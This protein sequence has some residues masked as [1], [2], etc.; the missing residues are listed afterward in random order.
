VKRIL[1][2]LFI[3]SVLFVFKSTQ[4]NPVSAAT[5]TGTFSNASG[6]ISVNVITF[7]KRANGANACL[8]VSNAIAAFS[9]GTVVCTDN[10]GDNAPYRLDRWWN[11]CGDGAS[12]IPLSGSGGAYTFNTIDVHCTNTNS[13]LTI[14]GTSCAGTTGHVDFRVNTNSDG[15]SPNIKNF[16]VYKS[17]GGNPDS[18]T[19]PLTVA[20][21]A[22]TTTYGADLALGATGNYNIS[23]KSFTNDPEN[24][25]YAVQGTLVCG[26]S[27]NPPANFVA[28]PSCDGSTDNVSFT[29]TGASPGTFNYVVETTTN[30]SDPGPTG[31]W[32]GPQ[33]GPT[34]NTYISSTLLTQAQTYWAHVKATPSPATGS[35]Y[36]SQ[37][38][39]FTVPTCQAGS[40]TPPTF[41]EDQDARTCASTTDTGDLTDDRT[42][43]YQN[44]V[45][46]RAKLTWTRA[47]PTNPLQ[48]QQEILDYGTNGVTYTAV[49]HS[50]FTYNANGVITSGTKRMHIL[51][52]SSALALGTF[53]YWRIRTQMTDGSWVT[54]SVRNFSTPS[55]CFFTPTTSPPT[56]PDTQLSGYI[57][58]SGGLRYVRLQFAVDGS[59]HLSNPNYRFDVYFTS[60]FGQTGLVGTTVDLSLTL[61]TNHNFSGN[62]FQ[63]V[64][65]DG[66]NWSDWDYALSLSQLSTCNA[67]TNAPSNLVATPSCSG[68]TPTVTFSFT[69]N[70]DNENGF[71]LDVTTEPF[72][73]DVASNPSSTWGTVLPGPRFGTGSSVPAVTWSPSSLLTSGNANPQSAGSNLVPVEATTYYWRVKALGN[74]ENS[75]YKYDDGTLASSQYPTGRSFT[76]APCTPSANLSAAIVP[77]SWRNSNG[78]QTQSFGVGE[79]VSVQI[80]VTNEPGPYAVTSPATELYFYFKGNNGVDVVPSCPGTA[81]LFPP[82]VDGAGLAQSYPISQLLVS[83]TRNITVTFNTGPSTGSATAYGYV[84]PSC[85]Y[86]G[87]GLGKD[88]TFSNNKTGGFT[89]TIGINKFFETK[90][91]DVGS[92]GTIKVGQNSS[93]LGIYQSDYLL[94]GNDTI[95]GS[96]GWVF[97]KNTMKLAAYSKNQVISGGVYKYFADRLRSKAMQNAELCNIT[98][99]AYSANNKLYYCTG[100]VVISNP[101]PTTISGNPIFFIDGNMT[102]TN[103][104]SI[105]V[106]VGSTA[107]FIV[108]GNINVA[109]SVTTLNGIYIAR[110]SFIDGD[111]GGEVQGL[112]SKLTLTGALYVDGEDGG[113]IDLAR[114]WGPDA[115]NLGYNATNPSE[116]FI[117]D[118]GYLVLLNTII[119]QSTVGW[120]EIAP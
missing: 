117:F 55:Y 46:S 5:I 107:M 50:S 73:S 83:E 106:A 17:L 33:L 64:M 53:Y 115:T 58:C 111:N 28:T 102:I 72:T 25:T 15:S 82:P 62:F 30:S 74:G 99:G 22:G 80:A 65:W 84:I 51:G 32:S 24:N 69:D 116:T 91:G 103:S 59:A 104:A 87:S 41:T 27:A 21:T 89:Y 112:A 75:I 119:A 67:V 37:A 79:N 92:K 57:Y 1:L 18:D 109:S 78:Q 93:S 4:A 31:Q 70:A 54:S 94:A 10:T 48:I 2:T 98:S 8:P 66:T 26:G 68:S 118:P 110:K 100:D 61:Q 97:S 9:T 7:F 60:I 14:T 114:H 29:W 105:N 40:G 49:A 36:F 81:D 42:D 56:K 11:S 43:N 108:K 38:V 52:A 16:Q 44:A 63:V 76:I 120:K 113:K 13:T 45:P 34:T 47:V 6:A 3:L 86:P 39:Q 20:Y 90:G 35:Y 71:Q 88:F 23:V 95:T 12:K 77:N 85:V 19:S 101:A 96:M